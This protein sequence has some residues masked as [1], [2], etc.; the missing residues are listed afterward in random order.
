MIGE[1]GEPHDWAGRGT[2]GVQ[3]NADQFDGAAGSG[4]GA[5]FCNRSDD[6]VPL[7]PATV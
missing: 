6:P 7:N 3:V 5:V 2:V 1:D 4:F